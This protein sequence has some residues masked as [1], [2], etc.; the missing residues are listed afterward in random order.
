MDEPRIMPEHMVCFHVPAW[1]G[2]QKV[3]ELTLAEAK[4]LRRD[5]SRQIPVDHGL[6]YQ[7][8]YRGIHERAGGEQVELPMFTLLSATPKWGE[9]A[10]LYRSMLDPADVQEI[11]VS[12]RICDGPYPYYPEP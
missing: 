6:R 1:N 4:A 10:R 12:A 9:L 8:V 2:E 11:F 5:L 3:F 7:Y